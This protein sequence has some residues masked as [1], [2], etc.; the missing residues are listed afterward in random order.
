MHL[1]KVVF[2]PSHLHI[3][4]GCTHLKGKGKRMLLVQTLVAWMMWKE[5]MFHVR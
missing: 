4:L 1:S 2:V 3:W 5:R